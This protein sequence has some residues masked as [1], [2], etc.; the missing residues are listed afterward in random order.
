MY[1]EYISGIVLKPNLPGETRLIF[2][3]PE[4]RGNFM[5]VL[6]DFWRSYPVWYVIF[7][8]LLMNDRKNNL[9]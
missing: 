6:K 8:S 7:S 5:K 2:D 9:K 3:Y 4:K 1:R